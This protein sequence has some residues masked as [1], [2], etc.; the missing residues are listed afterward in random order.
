MI[1]PATAQMPDRLIPC[2]YGVEKH[3][4]ACPAWIQKPWN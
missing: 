1:S 4:W 3:E 2:V